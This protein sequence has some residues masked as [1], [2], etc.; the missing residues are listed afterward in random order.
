MR[1]R[2]PLPD[3]RALHERLLT[4]L[5]DWSLLE[6]ALFPHGAS[7]WSKDVTAASL[8][9]SMHFHAPVRADE[10]LCHAMR[11]P[12]ASGARGFCLGE[13]WSESGVLVASSSQEGLIRSAAIAARDNAEAAPSDGRHWL[14]KEGASREP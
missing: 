5:S 3:D 11:S 8:T 9:H 6:T 10:W 13:I 4:Y 7:L 1:V 12:A 2:G 14:W